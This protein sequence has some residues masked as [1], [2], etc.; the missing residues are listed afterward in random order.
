MVDSVTA[1]APTAGKSAKTKSSHNNNN[2]NTAT[3]AASAASTNTPKA[4][5]EDT[6][7]GGVMMYYDAIWGAIVMYGAYIACSTAYVIRLGAIREYGPVIHEFDPY[8]NYRAT[9][10][11]TTVL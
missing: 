7:D 8:F 6:S 1:A 2:N 3:A 10:V 9:E 11:S 4:A 5:T